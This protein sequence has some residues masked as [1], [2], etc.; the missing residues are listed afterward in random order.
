[1]RYY[2]QFLAIKEAA[3]EVKPA[4]LPEDFEKVMHFVL[5][6]LDLPAAGDLAVAEAQPPKKSK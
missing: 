5:E 3:G 1:M 4:D 6:E 2:K